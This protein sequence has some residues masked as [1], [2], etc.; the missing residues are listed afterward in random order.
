MEIRDQFNIRPAS[1]PD[2]RLGFWKTH[3]L[4]PEDTPTH[5]FLARAILRLG[6][7]LYGD[8]WNGDEPLAEA[9][10]PLP[11]TLDPFTETAEV[12]RGSAL[13]LEYSP[14]YRQRCDARSKVVS[15]TEEEWATIVPIAKALAEERRQSLMRFYDVCQRLAR[16]FRNS[17]VLTSCRAF[18]G[19]PVRQLE[20]SIWNTEYFWGRFDI[21]R[22][23]LSDP[24][25]QRSSTQSGSWLFVETAS[26]ERALSGGRNDCCTVTDLAAL[27]SVYLSPYVRCMID[28]TIRLGLCVNNQLKTEFLIAE[29]PKYWKI[30]IELSGR[31][32]KSMA[33]L[34]REPESKAGRG[35]KA[36]P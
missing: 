16:T 29:L 6:E 19:G 9:I 35:K 24:F 36:M 32:L 20:C 10:E 22:I 8:K 33:T 14:D 34:M 13:L 21:C 30:P 25:S 27:N 28:A 1:R 11:E 17:V 3:F 18:D 2:P 4:W 7:T 23:D 26:F 5:V 15:P 12:L 31:D